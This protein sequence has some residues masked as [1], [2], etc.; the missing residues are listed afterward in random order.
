MNGVAVWLVTW[1]C[2]GSSSSLKVTEQCGGN[3]IREGEY[4]EGVMEK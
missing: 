2:R 1:F 4:T 3:G